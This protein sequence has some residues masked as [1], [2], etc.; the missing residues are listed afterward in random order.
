MN[1][2]GIGFTILKIKIAMNQDAISVTPGMMDHIHHRTKNHF[3]VGQDVHVR[4]T[5]YLQVPEAVP[6]SVSQDVLVVGIL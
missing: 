2:L 1:G 5:M 4:D 3:H 6:I